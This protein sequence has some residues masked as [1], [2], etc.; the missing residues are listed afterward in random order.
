MDFVEG[1]YVLES[2]KINGMPYWIQDKA[3][4]TEERGMAIWYEEDDDFENWNIGN[5]ENLGSSTT[6]MY[7][8]SF[9][10]GPHEVLTWNYFNDYDDDTCFETTDV[11]ISPAPGILHENNNK[12]A[13]L[14]LETKYIILHV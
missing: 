8:S 14:H 6:I 1:L 11:L 5:I 10:V 7:S 13:I 4:W 12:C 3:Y 2:D 9:T